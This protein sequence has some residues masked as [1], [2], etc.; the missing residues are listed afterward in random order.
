[1]TVLALMAQAL[2]QELQ[3]RG[4]FSVGA[5]DCEEIMSSVLKRCGKIAAQSNAANKG[6][7]IGAG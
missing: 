7:P 5:A 3:A 6:A 4:I 1:M 2:D